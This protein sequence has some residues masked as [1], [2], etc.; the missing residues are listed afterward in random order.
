MGIERKQVRSAHYDHVGLGL[1]SRSPL[2]DIPS[3][4]FPCLFESHNRGFLAIR[5][6]GKGAGRDSP[7][8]IED[9]IVS[10]QIGVLL[11]FYQVTGGLDGGQE[12]VTTPGLVDVGLVSRGSVVQIIAILN[13]NGLDF[14]NRQ[15]PMCP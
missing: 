2:V 1:P 12:S 9:P 14:L 3:L 13:V 8:V 11:G 7:W 4:R 10:T 6:S 15:Q 5:T